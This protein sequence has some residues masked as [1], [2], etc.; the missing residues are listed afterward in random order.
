[1]TTTFF[2][3]FFKSVDKNNTN[4]CDHC[5][6]KGSKKGNRVEHNETRKEERK[7]YRKEERRGVMSVEKH[8][9]LWLVVRPETEFCHCNLTLFFCNDSP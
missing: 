3:V 6:G 8:A 2:L 9:G 5:K 4:D 7:I 1:M